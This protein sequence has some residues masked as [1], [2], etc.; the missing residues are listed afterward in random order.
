LKKRKRYKNKNYSR[1]NE[2]KRALLQ[3][4]KR[5]LK[6]WGKPYSNMCANLPWH[7]N[8]NI[9]WLLVIGLK[10]SGIVWCLSSW[11]STSLKSS[12]RLLIWLRRATSFWKQKSTIYSWL[13]PV[14]EDFVCEPALQVYVERI[15][16]VCV[17]G[18]L[19]SGRR[20]SARLKLN[21]K[22]SV[23]YCMGGFALR[24]LSSVFMSD[25]SIRTI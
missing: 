6:I 5:K 11:I 3:T 16:S 22:V 2:R 7:R 24:A 18:I 15:F 19:C 20:S 8:A 13:C 21:Q 10:N 14:A 12:T 17:C 25:S 9:T 1:Q 4:K 23:C